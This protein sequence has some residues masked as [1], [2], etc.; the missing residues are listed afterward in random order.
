MSTAEE[1]REAA[2]G[3]AAHP[4]EQVRHAAEHLDE[5]ERRSDERRVGQTGFLSLDGSEVIPF[6]S[7]RGVLGAQT[8]IWLGM[9]D[10]TIALLE[11]SR[12]NVRRSATFLG[13]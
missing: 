12:D 5:P 3:A 11:I 7:V 9:I 6:G 4:T 2:N 10:A 1:A 8:R 13:R